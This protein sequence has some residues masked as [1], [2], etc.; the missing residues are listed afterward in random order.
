MGEVY[1]ARDMRLGREVAIKVLP[2]TVAADPDRVRRFEQEARA[3][4]SISHPNILAVHD[5]GRTD[6]GTPYIV[7]DLLEGRTLEAQRRQ[8]ALSIQKAI[9]IARQV[10]SGLAAAHAKGIVHRDLKP[11]NVFVS[12]D[13]RATILDFGLA[14]LTQPEAHAASGSSTTALATTPG[15]VLG[16]VAYMSPEQ[17]RGE[18]ADARSDLFALGAILHEMLA[19]RRPFEGNTT[20]ETM[21][22][23]LSSAPPELP[24]AERAIPPGLARIAARCL[25]K[26][27]AS[28]FQAASDLAFALESLSRGETAVVATTPAPRGRRTPA[29]TVAAGALLLAAVALAAGL[30]L[31]PAPDTRPPIF[32]NI[33]TPADVGTFSIGPPLALSPDGRYLA[34][35]AADASER[36]ILWVRRLAQPDAVALPGTEGAEAPFWSPDSRWVAFVADGAL[37]KVDVRGGPVV[38]VTAPVRPFPGSWNDEDVILFVAGSGGLSHVSADGGAVSPVT[39]PD[40]TGGERNHTY[41][42]FVTRDRFLYLADSGDDAPD[43]YL[44]A[45]ESPE[46]TLLLEGVS[47][48]QY[49]N[50][51]LLYVRDATLMARAL[52]PQ[53]A[54]RGSEAPI[55]DQIQM[56]TL[57]FTDG[58]ISPAGAFSVSRTGVLVYLRSASADSQLV[59]F[60]R[61]GERV[62][63]LGDPGA[64]TDVFLSTDGGTAYISLPDPGGRGTRDIWAYDVERG[65]RSRATFD[66]GDEFEGV[67]SPDGTRLAFNSTRDGGRDLYVKPAGGGAG[68][69]Q[70]VLVDDRDKYAQDWTPDGNSLVYITSNEDGL[71][72]IWV[73]PLVGDRTPWSYLATPSSEGA[74]VNVSPDGNW[75]AY[76]SSESGGQE[77]Y[78]ARFPDHG[79]RVQI[80][81]NGGVLP[82]WRRADGGEI[83]YFEPP[84]SRL[85]A[86]EL[87]YGP[88]GI[89]QGFPQPVATVEF[90]GPRSFYDV[91]PDGQRFLVNSLPDRTARTSISLIVDW[92]AL[93]DVSR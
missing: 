25:E 5:I 9:D 45:L 26:D 44:A 22:A 87:T 36:R 72:D 19:G 74:G 86:V 33:P 17:V 81:T 15:L 60:D 41:P 16:T 73:L 58:G 84:T 29:W 77:A 31:R 59:W 85:M 93:V 39:S 50:G 66:S 6:G 57:T 43:L 56:S 90:A 47:N 51:T 32:A 61:T 67:L 48:A 75:V 82:T 13:G 20:A 4:A 11:A 83:Y 70:A 24:V 35:A 7:S 21:A 40:R 30:Y 92:P 89:T 63:T 12:A 49:A 54:T 71:Q 68:S 80:S 27:P 37:K 46:R 91:T 14:K 64:Y 78:I 3:A 88:A 23:I 62:G 65:I 52:D 69:E 42:F 2:E 18:P 38:T 8:G 55:A 28:R 1:R 76:T 34:F 53:S 10:A 79:D